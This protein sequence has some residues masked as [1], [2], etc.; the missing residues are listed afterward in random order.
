[1]LDDK[2]IASM[3]SPFSEIFTQPLDQNIPSQNRSQSAQGP[4]H[5]LLSKKRELYMS[6]VTLV[7]SVHFQEGS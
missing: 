1:M 6:Q 7:D 4:I 5:L 3:K 2:V